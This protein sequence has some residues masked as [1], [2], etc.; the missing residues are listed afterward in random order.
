METSK[1]AKCGRILLCVAAM[2]MAG[3][4]V[5]KATTLQRMSLAQLSQTATLIVRAKCAANATE[6]DAGEIWTA[7]TFQVEETW[8]G[9][10]AGSQIRVRLIGGRFEKL[11]SNVSGVPRFSPGE[12]VVLFLEKTSHGDFAVV[13]W[14]Q[15]TFRIR[16]DGA[17]GEEHVTQDTASFA[18]FDAATRRFE[19][20]GI[21]HLALEEFR[22][23][24]DAALHAPGGRRP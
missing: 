11:T 2:L 21:R 13:S 12:D 16:R 10:A 23:R 17:S 4:T 8:S 7:T 20:E 9:A 24:V 5:V 22:A 15:G 19:A 14:E 18:T 3:S 6:W 1:K